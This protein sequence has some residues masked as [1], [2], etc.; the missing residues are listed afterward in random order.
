M[1]PALMC[2][3]FLVPSGIGREV[4]RLLRGSGDLDAADAAARGSVIV[5]AEAVL[6]GA[7]ARHGLFRD[8]RR[9]VTAR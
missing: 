3:E 9:R 7:S 5:D 6:D 1:R 4:A 8:P 2:F